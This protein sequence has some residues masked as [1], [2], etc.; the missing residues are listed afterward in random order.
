MNTLRTLITLLLPTSLLTSIAF[1]DGLGQANGYTIFTVKSFQANN[2]DCTGRVAVGGSA[3]YNNFGIGPALTDSDGSRD[4]LIVGGNLTWNNGENF[5]GNVQVTGPVTM[6]NVS[7]PNG[8]VSN[9]VYID[10]E[11]AETEL[12]M[13]SDL[14]Y[15][16]TP[17]GS[18]S[19]N[20]GHLTL[21]GTDSEMNIFTLSQSDIS[22]LKGMTINVPV[23]SSVLINVS[24]QSMQLKNFEPI[25]SG[26]ESTDILLNFPT[27]NSV[28]LNS[29]LWKGTI[30]A[31]NANINFKGTLEGALICQSVQGNGISR[32]APFDGHLPTDEECPCCDGGSENSDCQCTCEFDGIAMYD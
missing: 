6:N 15:S 26:C 9:D 29:N 31:P 24:H 10:F 8:T 5:N 3:T 19:N 22:P 12:Q 30:L 1:A 14:L 21:T 16:S 4:D 18:A 2:T 25:L 27:A 13:L 20:Q 11:S 7:M 23:G 17:N 28:N 32:H